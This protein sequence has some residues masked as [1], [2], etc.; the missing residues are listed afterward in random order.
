ME[1]EGVVMLNAGGA[2]VP[3]DGAAGKVEPVVV[4][5]L[6]VMAKLAVAYLCA[7]SEANTTT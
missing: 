2:L 5:T 7:A 6:R 3:G 1:V 4:P